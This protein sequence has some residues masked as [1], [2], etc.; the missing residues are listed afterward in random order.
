MNKR[1]QELARLHGLYCD[2]NQ[3]GRD[4]V[5]YMAENRHPF[6]G[7][8]RRLRAEFDRLRYACNSSARL[9]A[10]K[11][12]SEQAQYWAPELKVTWDPKEF[13]GFFHVYPAMGEKWTEY[14]RA[15]AKA[16]WPAAV[17]PGLDAGRIIV[18][19]KNAKLIGE[20]YG[21]LDGKVTTERKD[22]VHEIDA[23]PA[24][25]KKT[26]AALRAM[27]KGMKRWVLPVRTAADEARDRKELPLSEKKFRL[28]N[29]DRVTVDERSV[30]VPLVPIGQ[31]EKA[32]GIA[33]DL[34]A[35]C[36]QGF[37]YPEVRRWMAGPEGSGPRFVDPRT[38]RRLDKA[39]NYAA[40]A[41]EAVV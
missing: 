29:V 8:Y 7:D 12:A 33:N 32:L 23:Y 36:R 1:E 15:A 2:Y 21:I 3:D 30:L 39:F 20:L 37:P 6:A 35:L 10:Y 11:D 24:S 9:I 31:P 5:G 25:A 13:K 41:L 22:G 4:D 34:V 18:Q 14:L 27:R 26:L 16:G 38:L 28:A 17:E 40:A 19:S